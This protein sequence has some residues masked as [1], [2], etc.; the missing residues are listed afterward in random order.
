V[1][2]TAE[3]NENEIESRK[4]RGFWGW[5]GV[6]IRWLF[7]L[8][9][10]V[11]L[12]GGLY[13]KAPWK[14]LVLDAV[15]LALLT[16]VPKQK[17]KYGWL[18]LAAAVLAVT[19]WIFIPE[20]D[21]GNWR[22]YTFDEELAALEAERMVPP[23]DDAAP[24]YEALF[25][26]WE[27]IKTDDPYP[28]EADREDVTLGQPWTA[29][30]F[31]EIV[32]WFQRHKDF[33]NDLIAATQKPSCYFSED[34]TVSGLSESMERLNSTKRLGQHLIRASYL[35][36]GENR[37][38]AWEKQMAVLN[39]GKH[40][41]QQPLLIELL[42]GIALESM[43][44]QAMAVTLVGTGASSET[45]TPGDLLSMAA[46]IRTSHFDS[47][48]RWRHILAYEKLFA[49]NFWGM[50]Y[51]INPQG[52]IRFARPKTFFGVTRTVLPDEVARKLPN[53]Y[54]VGVGWKMSRVFI[55]AAGLPKDPVLVSEW[56]DEVYAPFEEALGKGGLDSEEV[57][58]ENT[59][60]FELNYKYAV[61]Q[62]VQLTFP[63]FK[64]IN[65]DILLRSE[66]QKRGTEIVCDLVLYK[67]KHGEYPNKLNELGSSEAEKQTVSDMYSGFM[68]R[69]IN[70][71]FLL[72]HIGQN[73]IDEN[74]Q[75][76]SRRCGSSP[77][78]SQCD[79]KQTADDILIWPRNE[80]AR[81]Q[82]LGIE[83]SDEVEKEMTPMM[84]MMMGR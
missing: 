36:I 40:V 33:F 65:N 43:A 59:G 29:M 56:V 16:V 63:S 23:E 76:E 84:P 21:T 34:A 48:E 49:K 77:E 3:I 51:E 13:F 27:Q 82:M 81:K 35:K 20:K 19:V 30:E 53:S 44:H 37:R 57:N 71:D 61:R 73:G 28:Y 31:P 62:A 66:R 70:N 46:A 58:K 10:T 54:W 41:Q 50:F 80:D 69:K 83:E 52:K 42:V 68:Y 67:K 18:T 38:V 47:R 8:L 32:A 79:K 4:K 64:K 9:F 15:L 78:D 60:P 12:L 25:E 2:N 5:C 1:E 39:F 22:P 72:Y 14:V 11:I 6:V 45:M 55:L 24:L 75:R 7:I 26:Q 74:G 17:R